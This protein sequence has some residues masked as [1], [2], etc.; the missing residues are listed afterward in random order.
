MP[1]VDVPIVVAEG[2]PVPD[3][4]AKARAHALATVFAPP[5]C[6]R[7]IRP[8]RLPAS[9]YAENDEAPAALPV[10]LQVLL[11]DQPPPE[12]LAT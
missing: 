10:F 3:G 7:W 12:A 4:T 11:A 9:S 5:P 6:R 1:I 8:A 2:N